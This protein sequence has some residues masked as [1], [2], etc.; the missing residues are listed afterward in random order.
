MC[1]PAREKGMK[2]LSDWYNLSCLKPKEHECILPSIALTIKI[3][4]TPAQGC[5]YSLLT[6]PELMKAKKLLWDN[7][8]IL[9]CF[10][11]PFE[12]CNKD[13]IYSPITSG[14]AYHVIVNARPTF[15]MPW[16]FPLSFLLMVLTLMFMAN[17][18]KNPSCSC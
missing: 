18:L 11:L 9:L 4:V 14:M 2:F 7:S 8:L 6:C 13:C 5:I 16:S 1:L 10:I 17:V 15:L 3:P 12:V